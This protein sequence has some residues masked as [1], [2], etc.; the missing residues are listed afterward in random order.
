MKK[1]KIAI[2]IAS[3]AVIALAATI[4]LICKFSP[5][6]EHDVLV[7]EIGQFDIDAR[8]ADRQ[9]GKLVLYTT[10]HPRNEYG[11][12]VLVEK[13]TN[14]VIA[15]GS[16]VSLADDTYI[17]SAHGDVAQRL[18][19]LEVGDIVD[20]KW[21]TAT[22]T[23]HLKLSNLKKIEINNKLADE[24]I[25][26]RRAALYD[27][28]LEAI[29]L[30]DQQLQNEIAQLNAYFDS[31]GK[32]VP[33]DIWIIDFKM[34]LISQL[35]DMKYYL[36]IEN[37]AVDGRAMW[38]AP[39]ITDIDETNLEGVKKFAARLYDMGINTLYVQ[40]YTCGMTMYYSDLLKYQNPRM[41]SYNYGEYG[42]DYILALISECH[43]LGIEVHAWFN[44]LET[45]MP[46][47]T[48]PSYIKDEWITTDLN[49]SKKGHFLD[50]S[51]PE[52][53]AFL[54]NV[55]NEILTKYD[56]D[57]I[58]YDYIRY[59]EAGEYKEYQDSGFSSNSEKLF[60][61]AYGYDG[62]SLQQ[63]VKND[64]E[65]RAMWHQFKQNAIN[66]LLGELAQFI[67]S[68]DPDA[69]ISASP[70]GYMDTAKNV[71]MQDVES[72]MKN[73]YIDVVLPMVY[74]DDVELHSK[75]AMAFKESSPLTIQYTG[76]YTLY[77]DSTMRRNQEIIDTLKSQGISGV[78]LFASQ[79]YITNESKEN[80]PIYR[81]LVLTTHKGHAVSPTDDPDKVLSAWREQLYD[82]YER[83]YSDKMSASEKEL[84]EQC[85][86]KLSL[87]IDD[88]VDIKI[89]IQLLLSFKNNVNTFEN[90]VAAERISS[91][92]DYISNI[93]HAELYRQ[94][95]RSK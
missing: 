71:Y 65:I 3:L 1:K 9:S 83:I 33:A 88:Y 32:G 53:S 20:I 74:T 16:M 62:K 95:L 7:Q 52:V 85:M 38:H 24:L 75:L 72:W 89:T 31:L 34:E 17:L 2:I 82:R 39:N 6:K 70:F 36:T 90:Q 40:T 5:K 79:N 60:A 22:V 57:G 49:G 27:I 25:E 84:F 81:I 37:Y 35:I 77:S 61:E 14:T 67:R 63:D 4:I 93:L 11:Y 8:N 23:R 87:E 46:N 58:S 12:E 56:F 43:K 92:I 48:F 44:V 68:I 54:K 78:S 41:A 15:E 29:E 64:P 47:G 50:P 94:S 28:D 91:Q 59:S 76:I 55:I 69:I 66:N 26:Q 19:K 30:T 73:G 10:D 42:N 18:R 13:S 45:E 51:N 80:D 86:N 21:N